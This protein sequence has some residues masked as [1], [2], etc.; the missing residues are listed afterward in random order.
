MIADDRDGLF[1]DRHGVELKIGQT[2]EAKV[3]I[4]PREVKRNGKVFFLGP[5]L[6]RICGKVIEVGPRASCIKPELKFLKEVKVKNDKI[7]IIA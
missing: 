3:N 1:R 6:D 5:Q 2:A 7:T 4:K